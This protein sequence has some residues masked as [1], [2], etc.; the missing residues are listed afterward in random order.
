LVDLAAAIAAALTESGTTTHG[1]AVKI[2]DRL[3]V[4]VPTANRRLARAKSGVPES[5]VILV[6]LLEV[7][8]Y[9]LVVVQKKRKED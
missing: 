1:T 9:E 7:M 8:G 3:G 6:G 4:S 5:V 2:A